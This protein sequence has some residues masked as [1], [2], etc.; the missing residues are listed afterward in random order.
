M[1][2]K[3][4]PARATR[5]P[6]RRKRDPSRAAQGTCLGGPRQ[7]PIS[8]WAL[9]R[10]YPVPQLL[11][12]GVLQAVVLGAVVEEVGAQGVLSP[13]QTVLGQDD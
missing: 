3:A 5:G 6:S 7:G 9:R 11:Q 8:L 4:L 12:P 13:V 10:G 1:T 2:L